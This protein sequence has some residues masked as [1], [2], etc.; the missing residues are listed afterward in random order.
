M[1]IIKSDSTKTIELTKFVESNHP[2]DCPEVVTVQVSY[3]LR[4]HIDCQQ[5]PET[6]QNFD[7]RAIDRL[8]Q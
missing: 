5:A 8:G 6:N 7:I 2:Y 1:L 4:V 3:L